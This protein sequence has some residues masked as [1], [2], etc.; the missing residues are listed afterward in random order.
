MK[1]NLQQ[2]KIQM[3]LRS[4]LVKLNTSTDSNLNR[5]LIVVFA[6]LLYFEMQTIL[7]FLNTFPS[8][9]GSTSALEFM[10]DRWLAAQVGFVGYDNKVTV[11]A[12]CRLFQHAI[13][14]EQNNSGD[15]N[16]A[17]INLNRIEV[18]VSD[19]HMGSDRIVTRSKAKPSR[20]V[21]CTVKILKLLINEYC[22]LSELNKIQN[23][24]P[25]SQHFDFDTSESDDE[26]R[27][28]EDRSLDYYDSEEDG[29]GDFDDVLNDDVAKIV[30]W[31]A[32]QQV[33]R[34]FRDKCPFG[35]DFMPHLTKE[36][37]KI[38]LDI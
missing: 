20:K 28:E 38:L 15:D 31:D 24:G 6:H 32:L 5:S 33:L 4:A 29:D 34:D 7:V 16:G 8:P 37:K 1:G 14:G 22:H 17:N 27:E 21:P 12:L 13:L 30:L 10:M 23:S 9:D 36:E 11:V 18:N 25:D 26:D 3:L 19:D 2:D 35:A